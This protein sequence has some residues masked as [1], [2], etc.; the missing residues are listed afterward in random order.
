MTVWEL[1]YLFDPVSNSTDRY[2]A[3]KAMLMHG[4]QMIAVHA[5]LDTGSMSSYLPMGIARDL[6]L[7]LTGKERHAVGGG[8]IFS[9]IPT[10]I[11]E[12]QLMDANNASFMRIKN[13]QICVSDAV[14][15]PLIGRDYVFPEVKITFDEAAKSMKLE[16]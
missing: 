7:D 13:M 14:P 12:C 9:Y 6:R 5:L 3:I 4:T 16:S 11:E 2:P 10:L 8:G 1:P 15:Y